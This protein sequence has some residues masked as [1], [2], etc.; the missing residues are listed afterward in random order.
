MTPSGWHMNHIVAYGFT[1]VF[2]GL[3]VWGLVGVL[4]GRR[5]GPEKGI[6]WAMLLWG[7]GGLSTPVLVASYML[8]DTQGLALQPTRC[9]PSTDSRNR[10][11]RKLWFTLPGPAERLVETR[12][13]RGSCEG[14]AA[15]KV[16][17]RVRVADLSGTQSPIQAHIDDGETHWA[18]GATIGGFGVVGLL[19]GAL[20]LAHSMPGRS[21]ERPA[22]EPAAWRK[23]LGETISWVGLLCMLAA[24][25]GPF[26]LDG[27]TERALQFGLRAMGTAVASFLLAGM[28]AGT[29]TGPAGIFLVVFSGAMFGFAQLAGL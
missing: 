5:R 25:I 6:A 3:L 19:M 9:E 12:V 11:L 24:F 27:T 18:I 4:V 16:P 14:S 7:I 10:P 1:M 28:V 22:K 13:E 17:L 20:L 26:L 23:S 29:M 8:L 2:G 15:F 21:D